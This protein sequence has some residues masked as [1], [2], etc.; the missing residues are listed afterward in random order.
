MPKPNARR[1][2]A[3]RAMRAKCHDCMA[4]YVDGRRDC[5]IPECPLYYWMP[6]RKQVP[7]YGW[8][9]YRALARGLQKFEPPTPEQQER[10]RAMAQTSR[11]ARQEQRPAPI[12]APETSAEGSGC[13]PRLPV[14]PTPILASPAAAAP[15]PSGGSVARPRVRLRTTKK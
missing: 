13:T 10:G 15:P 4:R 12:G 1:P 5:E 7:D 11:A 14:P 3:T 6:Y 9:Q 8:E 2:S